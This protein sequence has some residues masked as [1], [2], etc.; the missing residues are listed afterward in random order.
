ME[1]LKG[2][3]AH[4]YT[5]VHLWSQWTL[6]WWNRTGL[7]LCQVNNTDWSLMLNFLEV[8][9]GLSASCTCSATPAAAW[10][11]GGLD[12]DQRVY[13]CSVSARRSLRLE[14]RFRGEQRRDH[15]NNEPR[16]LGEFI[17]SEQWDLMYFN[18]SLFSSRTIKPGSLISLYH[19]GSR[20][21][22]LIV[23]HP[24]GDRA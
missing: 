19:P 6:R 24:I 10:L 8:P 13:H 4:T 1:Q 16:R 23:R 5:Y 14:T 9:T 11:R 2:A 12:G 22:R 21:S 3:N 20:A 18:T 17:S 7:R 15:G